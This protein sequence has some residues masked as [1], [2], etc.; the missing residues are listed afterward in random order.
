VSPVL[1]ATAVGLVVVAY[2][3]GQPAMTAAVTAAVG[4]ELRGAALG[5]ATLVFMIGASVGSAA[6]GGL[7]DAVG[8]PE[9]LGLVAILPVLGLVALH[10][11][12]RRSSLVSDLD[13][14]SRG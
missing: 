1:L 13:E 6:L 12:Q 14:V 7:G 10:P 11:L 2:S 5:I 8:I 4:P 9:A 3:I